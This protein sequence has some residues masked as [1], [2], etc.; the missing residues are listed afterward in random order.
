M[1][2]VLLNY[3]SMIKLAKRSETDQAGKVTASNIM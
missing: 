2:M 3:M 1:K